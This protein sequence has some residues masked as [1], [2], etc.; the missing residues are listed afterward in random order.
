MQEDCRE[1]IYNNT[2]KGTFGS[3]PA[4]PE[5]NKNADSRNLMSVTHKTL[6][7]QLH[8]EWQQIAVLFPLTSSAPN[9]G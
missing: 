9:G 6:D 1:T 5:H 4:K 8:H 3:V 2:L 7:Y